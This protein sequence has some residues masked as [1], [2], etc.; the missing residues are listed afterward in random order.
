MGCQ[1][2]I[3]GMLRGAK[4][5]SKQCFQTLLEFYMK[6]RAGTSG[7]ILKISSNFFLAKVYCILVHPG[8]TNTLI[9]SCDGPL[10][11]VSTQIILVKWYYY[12]PRFYFEGLIF[13]L[14]SM[15]QNKLNCQMLTHL[16]TLWQSWCRT[17]GLQEYRLNYSDDIYTRTWMKGSGREMYLRKYICKYMVFSPKY[18]QISDTIAEASNSVDE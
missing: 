7:N 16:L 2:R 14:Y 1:N 9:I 3:E 8:L 10:H 18:R 6:N 17:C 13:C 11:Q 12:Y 4:K 5:I 15:V